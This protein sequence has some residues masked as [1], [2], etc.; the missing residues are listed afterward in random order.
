MGTALYAKQ[1]SRSPVELL[2]SM[3]LPIVQATIAFYM[4]RAGS[5]VHPPIEAS[6]GAGLMGV[7]AYVLYGAGGSIHLQRIQGTLESLMLAPRSPVLVVLPLTVANAVVGS[8]AIF[9]TLGWGMLLFGV[10]PDFANLGAFLVAVPVCVLSLGM[11]GLLLAAAFVL[12]RNANALTNPMEYPI[13]LLSGMLVPVTVLPAWTSPLAAVLPTTWGAR[14]VQQAVSGGPVWPALA[15][16]LAEG[17]G[18]VA[19]GGLVL[20]RVERRA[21]MTATLALT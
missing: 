3:I 8:Y 16:C 11:L 7:W 18:C 21:R 13:W 5:H 10:R 14:A 6:V 2:T 1:L 17:I 12:L 9:A 4:F 15:V 19:L 20:T